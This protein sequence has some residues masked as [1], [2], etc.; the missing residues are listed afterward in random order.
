MQ[1]LSLVGHLKRS[2][3]RVQVA[4]HREQILNIVSEMALVSKGH[5]TLASGCE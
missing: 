4:H 2:R 3:I 5:D 1:R